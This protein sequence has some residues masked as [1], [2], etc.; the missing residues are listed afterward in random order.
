MLLE[1]KGHALSIRN[2]FL[3]LVLFPALLSS[4]CSEE[5]LPEKELVRPVR[6]MKVADPTQM[7]GRTF[8]GQ[9]KA[10]QELE[11]SFRV[12]GPLIAR[13]V[14]VGDTVKSGDVVAR[15]DPRDYEV[16]LRNAQGQLEQARAVEKR[17]TSDYE[18]LKRIYEQD[19]G[20]TSEAAVDRARQN[21]DSA[22]ANVKSLGASVANAKDKLSYTYLKA[23]FDGIVV[24]TYKENFEDVR[25]KQPVVRIIDNSRIEMVVNIPESL[26]S[27]V[28]GVKNIT[29]TFDP[30]PD[31]FIPAQV[32]EIS[33]EAS[34]STRTYPVT[35]IMD[36]PDDFKILPGMAGK[37]VGE[38]PEGL[39]IST[40]EIPVS[41][42]FS[43]EESPKSYVW[44]IDE[45]AQK[46]TRR[47]VK[48]GELTD[49]GIEIEEG[50]EPGEWIATAG[51]HYLV[52]GQKV[53]VQEDNSG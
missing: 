19:P 1:I 41:A 5:Q 47:E 14:N 43:R 7:K 2:E 11:L 42:V 6:A 23:P 4:G 28:P 48:T 9:A 50:L 39:I 34:E 10:T 33:A 15:I 17:A 25:A 29:V 32:K 30:Y 51:V 44:V 18:R 31:H 21:R 38:P 53:I 27:Y 37:A 13:S 45:Q 16:D 36:Q 24:N 22:R 20:A 49:H 46:V 8:P 52:D 3:A 40:A 12:G 26:I 35:L